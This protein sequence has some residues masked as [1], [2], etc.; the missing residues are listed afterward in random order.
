M[1]W[2]TDF[3]P[4]T[5]KYS[6]ASAFWRQQAYIRYHL[7]IDPDSLDIAEHAKAFAHIRYV[8][9]RN[10]KEFPSINI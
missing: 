10:S 9:E 8:V 6:Y 1:I 5:E 2:K 3:D 7:G 4:L